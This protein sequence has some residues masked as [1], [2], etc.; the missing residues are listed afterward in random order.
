MIHTKQLLLITVICIVSILV[1]CSG[2]KETG[3][4]QDIAKSG[5]AKVEAPRGEM[6]QLVGQITEG[7][8]KRNEARRQII[9][10]GH[11]ATDDLLSFSDS[12]EYVIRWEIANI[13][14]KTKDPKG[15]DTLKKYISSLSSSLLVRWL[16]LTRHLYPFRLWLSFIRKVNI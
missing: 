1:N 4:K 16:S 14:G 8:E 5:P 3:T 9:K 2:K 7:T 13:L 10:L 11:S 12:P 15:L 6:A